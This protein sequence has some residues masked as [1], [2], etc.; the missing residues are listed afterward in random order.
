MTNI[1][2]T[3]RLALAALAI[4]APC[5]M[6]G[7]NI[8]QYKVSKGGAV[9]KGFSDGT[10][11]SFTWPGGIWGLFPDGKH[12]FNPRTAE[13][14]PIGF[15]FRLGGVLFDQF[16]PDCNG[17][18]YL[19]NGEVAFRDGAFRVG[20]SPIAHGILRCDISYKTTGSEGNRV[21]TVQYKGATL[22]TNASPRG[23][24]N[25]QIRLYE[26]DGKIE[27]AFSEEET[28]NSSVGGFDTGLEGWDSSDVLQLTAAGLD[29]EVSVSPKLT[30]DVLVPES[31]I[32]W[33]HTDRD[34]YYEPTFV[35]TPVLDTT[36]PIGAPTG[37]SVEQSG[38]ELNISC[39]RGRDAAATVVL[40]SESPFTDDDMPTDGETFRAAYI[41]SENGKQIIPTVIGNASALYYGNSLNVATVFQNVVPGTKYYVRAISANGYPAYNRTNVA[42]YEYQAPQAPPSAMSVEAAGLT[43]VNVAVT[44]ENP[45]IIAKT[46]DP[47]AGYN[48]GYIGRFGAPS[49]DPQV[50]DMLAGGGEIVYIGDASSIDVNVEANTMTY[51]RAWT[52]KDGVV[53]S[54]WIDAVGVSDPSLPYAPA[55]ET[56][57]AGESIMGWSASR[58]NFISHRRTYDGESAVRVKCINGEVATM[59]SPALPLDVPVRVSFEFAMETD[60]AAAGSEDSG[61]ILLPSGR[62]AGQFGEGGYLNIS[63]NGEVLNSITEYNGSMVSIAEGFEDDSSSFDAVSFEMPAAGS[64]AQLTF[65]ARTETSSVIYIR[66]IRIE[67]LEVAP[68]APVEAPT[69]LTADEDRNAIISVSCRRAADAEYTAVLFSTQPF[70]DADM[71]QDGV[72]P[73][74]GQTVGNATVLYFGADEDVECATTYEILDPDYDTDYYFRAIAAS[75]NALYNREKVADFTY[76]TLP[77][78]GVPED[79]K[80][81]VDTDAYI[82]VSATRNPNAAGTLILLSSDE[83]DGQKNLVDGTVYNPGDTVGNAMVIYQGNDDIIRATTPEAIP[84]G[85]YVVT[86][87]SVNSRGWFGERTTSCSIISVGIESVEAD[88][89]DLSAAEIYNL[90]GERI[91]VGPT[92][93]LP[94]GIYIVNGKKL[95]INQ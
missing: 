17:N 72:E 12:S 47:A 30:A 45:V 7:G 88:G 61:D 43:A 81:S 2:T 25:L 54:T 40:I 18:L 23:E 79:M 73:Q 16:V 48:M 83:F 66:N 87:I 19:G 65:A 38:S 28:T 37:L 70:T 41:N 74:A 29:L 95:N 27:F 4:A 78:A 94:S 50:G 20:M 76:R 53:S 13:G 69:A 35:L 58:D 42:D 59:T 90:L 14:F 80:V 52:L 57:P 10:K 82:N 86:G 64:D 1:Y 22:N 26:A 77:D 11:I 3:A 46:T 15:E 85:D 51:F 5:I 49:S 62:E 24:Y 39:R 6:L 71:P 92:D 21:L 60:R 75:G 93:K 33:D 63:V 8:P 55:I 31:F 89:I 44:A 32:N 56:Y 91:H 84:S 34:M 36:A 9:Y 68:V 67:P